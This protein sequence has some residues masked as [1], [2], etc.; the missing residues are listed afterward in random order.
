[1]PVRDFDLIILDF[2]GT[3][4]DS[5]TILVG[6]V[7]QTLTAHG[8]PHAAE[9]RVAECIGLPLPQVFRNHVPDA[10]DELITTLTRFYRSH[11]DLPDFVRKFRLFPGV[12]ATLTRLRAAGARLVIGTSKGHA[13]TCDILKHCEIDETIDRVIGGDSVQR[14]KPHP[15][16]IDRALELYGVQRERALMVGDTSFDIDMGHAAGVAT[17]AVTY[18][19]QPAATLRALRPRFVI[20]RIEELERIVGGGYP[21]DRSDPPDRSDDLSIT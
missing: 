15:E 14:G 21:T 11:A 6:M 18:G 1:M 2:D 16:T 9:Q 17:C 19:M 13:T 7:N 12:R 10:D 8:L 4:A 20:D 3:L 5:R